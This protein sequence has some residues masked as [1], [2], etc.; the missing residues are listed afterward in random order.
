MRLAPAFTMLA[1]V[2]PAFAANLSAEGLDRSWSGLRSSHFSPWDH[3]PAGHTVS[4]HIAKI[5]TGVVSEAV[6]SA[7][8]T[9]ERRDLAINEIAQD[10]DAAR[11]S[12]LEDL[13]DA[14]RA[15]AS[16]SSSKDDGQHQRFVAFLRQIVDNSG[17]SA[18]REP[19]SSGDA[20]LSQ[21]YDRVIRNAPDDRLA[22]IEAS[23]RAWVAYRDAFDLFALSMDRPDA[24]KSVHDDLAR[25]RAEE[26]QDLSD[27]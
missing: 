9:G 11:R 19:S 26:L 23:E 7:A 10:W 12:A 24:A 3:A 1:L 4:A 14:Q 15:Y 13:R 2:S 25:H 18:A 17:R 20:A 16:V 27:R 6:A 22:A 21:A 5:R 8:K